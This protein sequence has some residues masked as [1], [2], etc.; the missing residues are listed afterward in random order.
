MNYGT[1]SW[2]RSAAAP[3]G[4]FQLGPVFEDTLGRVTLATR[5]AESTNFKRL[6][7]WPEN[8]DSD[9]NSDTTPTTA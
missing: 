6:R 1:D 5:A 7:L 2:N 9:S 8:I 4:R 3:A